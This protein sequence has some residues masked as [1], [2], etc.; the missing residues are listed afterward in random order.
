MPSGVVNYQTPASV[1]V[2]GADETT[3]YSATLNAG[4]LVPGTNVLAVE[5]H[6]SSPGSSDISFD[7]ELTGVIS[8]VAP[9]IVVQ[10]ASVSALAGQT[11]VFN[12]G[13]DGSQPLRVS[14]VC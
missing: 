14:W 10:P 7:L 13:V 11:A 8:V 4:Y 9:Y 12:V 3:F 2:G 5:I 6:Q 1:A